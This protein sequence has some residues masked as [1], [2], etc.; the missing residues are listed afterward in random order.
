LLSKGPKASEN[1]Y[2]D[3][4][5]AKVDL[6]KPSGPKMLWGRTG[7]PSEG[8]GMGAVKALTSTPSRRRE[9]KPFAPFKAWR[10]IGR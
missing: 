5:D 6:L 7:M 8:S 4:G 2:H 10:E 9:S 1:W 3:D